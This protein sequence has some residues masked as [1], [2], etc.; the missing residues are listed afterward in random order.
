[1]PR[2]V[3]VSEPEV[4]AIL[5]DIGT[6]PEEISCRHPEVVHDKTEPD[7]STLG[8]CEA[9]GEDSFMLCDVPSEAMTIAN[10]GDS[11]YGRARRT[12]GRAWHRRLDQQ[13]W[14]QAARKYLSAKRVKS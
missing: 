14:K 2:D 4:E 6:D 13:R 12:H 9:C 1:M 5:G 7:G 3:N 11:P 8:R 10:G